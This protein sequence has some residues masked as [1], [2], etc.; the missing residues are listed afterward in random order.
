MNQ[1]TTVAVY[2]CT[3]R[4]NELLATCLDALRTAAR[5]AADLADVG[6]VV[7]DDNDDGRAAEVARAADH[8][9]PLGV[10]YVHVGKGNISLARN[11]GLEAAVPLADWVAM[12]DDDCQPD[13]R[14][15]VELLAAQRRGDHDAV[16]GPIR[17]TPPADAPP[18]LREQPFL[19]IDHEGEEESGL[20]YTNNSMIRSSFLASHPDIRFDPSLGELGGEDMVFYHQAREA[21]L[22]IGYSA[23]AFVTSIDDPQRSTFG[24]HLRYHLWLG[25]TEA[26]TNLRLER[27]GRLRLVARALR[28]LGNAV[29][30]PFSR[31]ASR[32]SPQWRYALALSVAACG[33]FA[34]ALGLELDHPAPR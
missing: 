32:E 27:A 33:L 3:Y 21:G 20:A 25:N 28:R 10:H 16:T 7:V 12:T 2:V 29:I 22:R 23:A 18:W 11:A 13:E 31:L 15:I 24:H 30:R 14:W 6:V 1:R 26:I 34:G 4:R 5:T 19:A 9:F 8:G 17:F